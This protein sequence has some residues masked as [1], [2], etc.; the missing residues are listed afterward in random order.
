MLTSE[1]SMDFF[2]RV[3]FDSGN[4]DYLGLFTFYYTYYIP[5][6]ICDLRDEIIFSCDLMWATAMHSD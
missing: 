5:I 1:L 3:D 4:D 2:G 6:G